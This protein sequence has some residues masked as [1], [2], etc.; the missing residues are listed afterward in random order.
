MNSLKSKIANLSADRRAKVEARGQELIDEELTLR[1]LRELLQ[2]T[3]AEIATRLEVGQH[4]V[5]RL[6]SRADLKLSTLRTYVE[7]LGGELKVSATFPKHGEIE[8]RY[9]HSE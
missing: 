1:Q 8:I 9:T 5:S 4:S 6:E 2:M 7:A 3:Q